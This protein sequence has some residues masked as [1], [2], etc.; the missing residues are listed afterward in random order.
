MKQPLVSYSSST[1]NDDDNAFEA[2]E[3]ERDNSPNSPLVSLGA[4]VSGSN[5]DVVLPEL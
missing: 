1:S 3:E 5:R 4:E 2:L